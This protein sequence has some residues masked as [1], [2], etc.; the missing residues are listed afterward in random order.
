[1]C[2]F[3]G[4]TIIVQEGEM[5]LYIDANSIGSANTNDEYVITGC[6]RNDIY[7]E[8]R[9]DRQNA[10]RDRIIYTGEKYCNFY[11]IFKNPTQVVYDDWKGL[12]GSPV[13]NSNGKL[14]GMLYR[15]VEETNHLYVT[16]I[17]TILLIMRHVCQI[18]RG[19]E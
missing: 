5:K 10:F 2:D 16:P 11:L 18:Q 13:F 6:I 1:M 12:S 7:A 14:I 19:N 8:I 4:E 9:M 3:D 17:Q 15:V